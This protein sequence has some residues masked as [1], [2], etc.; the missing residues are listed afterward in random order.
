MKLLMSAMLLFMTMS[1]FAKNMVATC[2]TKEDKQVTEIYVE[3]KSLNQLFTGAKSVNGTLL[4][5]EEQIE[6]PAIMRKAKGANI[7]MPIIL[8][9]SSFL[10]NEIDF[11]LNLGIPTSQKVFVHQ[12]H[13]GQDFSYEMTCELK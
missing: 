9:T 10:D 12:H 5:V 7:D 6:F 1:A 2:I 4:L 13:L 3:A 8:V 11:N